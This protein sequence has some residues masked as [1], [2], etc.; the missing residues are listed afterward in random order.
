MNNSQTNEFIDQAIAKLEENTLKIGKCLEHLDDGDIWKRPNDSSNSVGNILIHLCGNMTQYIVSSLG[1]VEDHRMRDEEFEARAGG[2]K[3]ELL[4]KLST[5]VRRSADV[6][7]GLDHEDLMRERT[8][9]GF[10]LTG[11][12]IILH[13]VEHYSYHTGQ[14]AFWVKLLADKDLDLYAGFDLNRKNEPV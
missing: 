14:I 8:V 4:E 9:Q 5:T 13:V 3:S 2:S 1:G 7:R 6:I 11:I 12:G 10:K